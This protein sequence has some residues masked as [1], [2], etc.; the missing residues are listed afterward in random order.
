MTVLRV[1]YPNMGA[2]LRFH[3]GLNS[4]FLL[5]VVLVMP[6][7]GVFL[8]VKRGFYRANL[9]TEKWLPNG[10]LTGKNPGLH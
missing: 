4:G 9:N 5:F 1:Q 6:L 8:G 10:F 3:A 2:E 7:C